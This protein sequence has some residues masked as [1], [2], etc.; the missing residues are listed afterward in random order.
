MV[1]SVLRVYASASRA[2][3][4]RIARVDCDYRNA[5]AFGFVFQKRAQLSKRPVPQASALFAAG[6]NLIANPGQF[7]NRNPASSAFSIQHDSLRYAVVSVSLKPR[8]FSREFAEPALCGLSPAPLQARATLG[9]VSTNALDLSAAVDLAIAAGG[10]VDDP[11]INAEPIGRLELSCF[12]NVACRGEHPFAAHEAKVDLALSVGEQGALM[13]T[14]HELEP[15]PALNGPDRNLVIAFEAEDT[16][17]VGL[18][19]VVSKDGSDLAIDLEG[20]GHLGN[21]AHG[22]L[23]G[24]AEFG[25]QPCITELVQVELAEDS[26]RKAFG[27]KRRA[28]IVATFQRRLK[29]GGLLMRW[30]QFYGRDKFHASN[31][32][33]L[34]PMSRARFAAA[35]IPPR[36]KCRGFSR[37]IR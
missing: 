23:R 15:H 13:V 26:G 5:R 27:G 24:Q 8:L 4:A 20:V 9:M 29:N 18:G 21:A 19:R 2:T 37:R 3:F 34:M 14:G 10:D 33:I 30:Q 28:C 12:G 32:E 36:P 17:I 7:L 1:R 16:I 6:R 11:K 31:I 35:A 22:G 25:A